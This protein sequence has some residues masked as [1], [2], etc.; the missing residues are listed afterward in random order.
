M[1]LKMS[2]HSSWSE[3]LAARE[4]RGTPLRFRRTGLPTPNE[5]DEVREVKENDDKAGGAKGG[6]FLLY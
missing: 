2:V 4:Q 3:Q 1:K 5:L 6:L